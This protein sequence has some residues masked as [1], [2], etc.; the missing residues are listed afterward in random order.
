MNCTKI[1]DPSDRGSRVPPPWYVGV[2]WFAAFYLG[3]VE[4]QDNDF[5]TYGFRRNRTPSIIPEMTSFENKLVDNI[6]SIQSQPL[7]F[8]CVSTRRLCIPIL[9]TTRTQFVT[10]QKLKSDSWFK[11]FKLILVW[12]DI[13]LR[14]I[15]LLYPGQTKVLWGLWWSLSFYGES[16]DIPH[17]EQ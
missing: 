9:H 1:W 4:M 5:E 10:F 14:E 16:F 15:A 17:S 3:I 6:S 12:T 8:E 2:G 13:F 11:Q 7:M